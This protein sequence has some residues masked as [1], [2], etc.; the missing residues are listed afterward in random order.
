[1]ADQMT[2]I[3]RVSVGVINF[4]C[5]LCGCPSVFLHMKFFVVLFAW[6]CRRHVGRFNESGPCFCELSMEMLLCRVRVI[7]RE[8]HHRSAGVNSS[9]SFHVRQQ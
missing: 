7:L 5:P 2:R 6:C 9:I 3:F 4:V 8:S 1:M